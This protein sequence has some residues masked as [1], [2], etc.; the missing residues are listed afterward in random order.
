[1]VY[2]GR[3]DDGLPMTDDL[4]FIA[5]RWIAE[6]GAA[7]PELVRQWAKDLGAAPTAA[8]F[9]ERIATA[10][11]ALLREQAAQPLP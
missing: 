9:L 10:A 1:M 8:E 4:R 3:H 11:E 2:C 7:T 6:H 5:A